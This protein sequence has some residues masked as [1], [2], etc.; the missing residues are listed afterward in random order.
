MCET[1]S[2]LLDN[3]YKILTTKLIRQVVGI[4]MGMSCAP[5]VSDL[6]LFYYERNLTMCL[7]KQKQSEVIAAKIFGRF[8]IDNNYFDG[9]TSQIYLSERQLNKQILL[10][11]KPRFWICICLL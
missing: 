2:F 9:L 11:P 7:S 3:L 10:K 5:F 8:I 1:L 6:L 4:P